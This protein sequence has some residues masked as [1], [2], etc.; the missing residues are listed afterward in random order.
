MYSA[1]PVSHWLSPTVDQYTSS[2]LFLFCLKNSQMPP[3]HR[4]NQEKEPTGLCC[5]GD[6]IL[7]YAWNDLQ[8]KDM[9]APAGEIQKSLLFISTPKLIHCLKHPFC[10]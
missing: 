6:E 4:T 2:F 8:A 5:R 1:S 3:A 9:E 7:E 10:L